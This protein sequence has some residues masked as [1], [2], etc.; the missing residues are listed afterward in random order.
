M[1]PSYRKEC[2]RGHNKSIGKMSLTS[3]SNSPYRKRHSPT[4]GFPTTTAS[5]NAT[6]KMCMIALLPRSA[7]RRRGLADILTSEEHLHNKVRHA[8][9]RP[10]AQQSGRWSL[11]S[12]WSEFQTEYGCDLLCFVF[13][14]LPETFGCCASLIVATLQ[15]FLFYPSR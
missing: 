11:S 7:S 2:Q 12:R 4:A 15:H 9:N 3:K 1:C 10:L 13:L 8:S 5:A 14:S 6:T